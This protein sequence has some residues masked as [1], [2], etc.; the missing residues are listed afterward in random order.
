MTM[1]VRGEERT[2]AFCG[3]GKN[4]KRVDAYACY[5]FNRY[6]S[7]GD[8][9]E[10]GTWFDLCEMHFAKQNRKIGDDDVRLLVNDG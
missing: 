2:C 8:Y 5:N 9:D 7:D 4:G 10:R 1:I 3:L 6:D